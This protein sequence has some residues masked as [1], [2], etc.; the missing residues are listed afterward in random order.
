[1]KSVNPN[2]SDREKIPDSIHHHAVDF[3]CSSSWFW[4]AG[5]IA[6][7]SVVKRVN[8]RPEN[9]ETEKTEWWLVF[10]WT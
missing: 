9:R 10:K 2:V 4:L 8:E 1:M 5:R 7:S 6:D 3:P